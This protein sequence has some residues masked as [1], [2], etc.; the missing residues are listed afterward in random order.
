MQSSTSP[1]SAL[2]KGQPGI[3]FRAR[4]VYSPAGARSR[5][6]PKSGPN[7]RPGSRP[8]PAKSPAPVVSRP[9][10]PAASSTRLTPSLPAESSNPAC[11]RNRRRQ[12]HLSDSAGHFQLPQP[13]P[14]DYTPTAALS[15]FT[16]L[17][18]PLHIARA[19]L[20]PSRS[21]LISLPLSPASPSTPTAI[22]SPP[23][24][25]NPRLPVS[26]PPDD[27]K[28]LPYL[29][30][31]IVSTLSA[32][33]DMGVAGEGG[34]HLVVD[35]NES[36]ASRRRTSSAI[37]R[38]NANQDPY[39][40]QYLQ[41]RQRPGRNHHQGPPADSLPRQAPASPSATPTLERH[42]LLRHQ[43]ATRSAPHLRGL[44]LRSRPP[45]CPTPCFLFSFTRREV[46][47]S[48]QVLATTLPTVLPE[49]NVLQ[50]TR[51]TDSTAKVSH[52]Y[53]DHHSAY[54]LYYFPRLPAAPTKASE[55]HPGLKPASP[56]TS[57]TRE[58][59][60]YDDPTTSCQQAEPAL[61]LEA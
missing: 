5:L 12:C 38:I 61:N 31:D 13:L 55:A 26:S 40:A 19:P 60:H 20:P 8:A 58:F 27:M 46:D 6:R 18:H 14:G 42:Q 43:Q 22:P 29:D 39:S 4:P 7:A 17:D 44:P 52:Q 24:P 10:S 37:E 53:N 34:A 23:E 50:A 41:P 35:G 56:P 49:Q 1:P 25:E 32:F 36:K 30:A 47:T 59:T 51:S 57:L 9:P 11:G 33:L 54:L 3:F 21:P 2:S 45:R 15:G 28:G 48:S 16:P